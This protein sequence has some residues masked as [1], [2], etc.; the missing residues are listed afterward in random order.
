MA[1]VD[2]ENGVAA[3]IKLLS[4]YNDTN[5]AVGDYK[6]LSSGKP[7]VVILDTGAVNIHEV[8]Q[9]TRRMRTVWI[10]KIMLFVRFSK[11]VS[12]ISA[13][14]RGYRQEIL[15]QLDKYPTLNGVSGVITALVTRLSQ[16]AIWSGGERN[17]WLQTMDME[18]EERYTVALPGIDTPSIPVTPANRAFSTAFSEAFD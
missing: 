10:V 11:D 8:A 13:D 2:V 4:G 9:S 16:P 1:Y 18:V 14:I 7:R 6:V 15:D 17:W 3:V 5:V 12:T